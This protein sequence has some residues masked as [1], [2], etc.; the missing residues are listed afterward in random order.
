MKTPPNPN[1]N[2]MRPLVPLIILASAMGTYLTFC[3]SSPRSISEINLRKIEESMNRMNDN[4]KRR[5][6][7]EYNFH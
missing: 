6:T 3:D 7:K 1:P 5:E 2:T 4:S